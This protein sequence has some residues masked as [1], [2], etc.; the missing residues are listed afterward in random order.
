MIKSCPHSILE[1]QIVR[2]TSRTRLRLSPHQRPLHLGSRLAPAVP[3][4]PSAAGGAARKGRWH[5]LS[6]R[7][8]GLYRQ[9]DVALLKQTTCAAQPASRC[10]TG[11]PLPSTLQRLQEGNEVALLV[12]RQA[13]LEA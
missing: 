9:V 8:L 4:R 7:D 2:C 1:K 10:A 5:F 12:L 6:T 13:D 3:R 11:E